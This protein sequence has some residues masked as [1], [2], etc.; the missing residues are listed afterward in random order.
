[1]KRENKIEKAV[2]A[3]VADA[4]NVECVQA[5][6]VDESPYGVRQERHKPPTAE[7]CFRDWFG[8]APFPLSADKLMRLVRRND[9]WGPMQMGVFYFAQLRMECELLLPYP[10]LGFDDWAF[11][12]MVNTWI[13]N[14]GFFR[15]AAIG[16]MLAVYEMMRS[17]HADLQ[18]KER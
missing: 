6:V 12:N 1:M 2:A 11:A 8:E 3:H 14:P 17:E 7:R 16:R 15:C 9:F 10:A 5:E 13:G 4:S 18:K